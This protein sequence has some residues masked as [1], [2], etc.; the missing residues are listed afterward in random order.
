MGKNQKKLRKNQPGGQLLLSIKTTQLRKQKE[1]TKLK[2]SMRSKS[3]RFTIFVKKFKNVILSVNLE[4]LFSFETRKIG[5]GLD[6]HCPRI[7]FGSY[8]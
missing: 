1:I 2:K 6:C 3:D 7:L 8:G 4:Y 5:L